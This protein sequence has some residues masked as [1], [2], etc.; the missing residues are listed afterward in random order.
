MVSAIHTKPIKAAS[1]V[2]IRRCIV[3]GEIC[4]I[5]ATIDSFAKVKAAK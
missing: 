3:M 2:V 4:R 5:N 1:P